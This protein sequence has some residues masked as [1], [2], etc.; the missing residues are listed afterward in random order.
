[1]KIKLFKTTDQKLSELGF[2]IKD[3]DLQTI[4][5]TRYDELYDYFQEVE[6]SK[7]DNPTNDIMIFSYYVDHDNQWNNKVVVGLTVKEIKLFLKKIR[8][9]IRKSNCYKEYKP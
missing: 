7:Q 2:K 9:S 6:I 4:R 5:Y 3:E 8:E 1:M